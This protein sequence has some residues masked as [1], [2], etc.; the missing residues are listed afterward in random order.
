MK[1]TFSKAERLSSTKQIE[2]LYKSGKSFRCYPLKITVLQH[3]TKE[4]NNVS[5]LI[6]APK[7][8]F[9][10][11]NQRNLI[12]R[13]IRESYRTNKH[14]FIDFCK[15]HDLFLHISFQYANK[16]LEDFSVIELALKNALNNIEKL[17]IADSK[18]KISE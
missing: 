10:H 12:K 13:R 1:N 11:A 6:S 18:P 9:K 5:I 8:F 14:Q 4:E 17:L 15:N 2:E 7:H 16:K 3:Q